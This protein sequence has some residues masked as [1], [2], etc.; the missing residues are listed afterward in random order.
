MDGC[1]TER[2]KLLILNPFLNIGLNPKKTNVQFLKQGKE[3]NK[4]KI[5]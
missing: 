3:M 5:D 4:L 2:Q 1:T